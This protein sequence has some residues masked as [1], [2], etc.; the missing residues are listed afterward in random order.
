MPSTLN[1]LTDEQATFVREVYGDDPAGFYEDA[2]NTTAWYKQIE[3]LEA[4]FKYPKVAVP[5][6]HESGKSYNAARIIIT[7]LMTHSPSVVIVTAPT[8]NQVK[9]V[10][11]R[12][13]NAAYNNANIPLGPKP[14]TTTWNLSPDWYAIGIST[15]VAE[16][17]AG[18]HSNDILVVVDEASGV[19]EEI[20]EGIAGVISNRNAR[21]LYLGNPTQIDGTFAKECANPLVK[22][23][24]V[25]AFDTPNFTANNIRD[26]EDLLRIFTPPEG[27]N[28]LDHMMSAD[29]NLTYAVEG[30][31][32]PRWAY[33]KYLEWGIDSPL[34]QSRV[35][36]QFPS[37]A[38]DALFN[39]QELINCMDPEYREENGYDVH[40]GSPEFGVDVARFG[41]DHTVIAPRRGGLVYDMLSYSKQDTSVTAE[42][43]FRM[44]DLTD[45]NTRI[46][47]D[48]TGVGGGVTDQL[49]LIRDKG[50]QGGQPYHFTIVPINFGESPRNKEKFLNRRAE[51]YWNL[52]ELV[53]NHK[54]ALPKDD[55][56]LNELASIHYTFTSKQQIQIES[57]DDIKKRTGKSPDRADA[58]VLAFADYHV[59]EADVIALARKRAEQSKRKKAPTI[60]GNQLATTPDLR[61]RA[62]GSMF[63]NR[64]GAGQRRY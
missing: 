14:N 41:S 5:S 9:N 62:A 40:T 47:V 26:T 58:L 48:D 56:L 19:K 60:V 50:N 64:S 11:W 52:R 33:E 46:K 32:S 20:F 44:L 45:W 6:C 27:A 25:S 2:L 55:I 7:Y 8:W 1:Q 49:R 53:H 59:Q 10:I 24:Q 3:I 57:K 34:W 23:F 17:F 4:V 18:F 30:L 61:T 39:L 51:M 54:V 28:A 12:G 42:R 22:V 21:I 43:V 36:G 31:C 13:I 35:M 37:Q 38:E 63:G 15:N 29:A 16:N